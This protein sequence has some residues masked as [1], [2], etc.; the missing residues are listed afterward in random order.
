MASSSTT[1]SGG[2]L[3]GYNPH[4]VRL[5]LLFRRRKIGWTNG[6]ERMLW[7]VLKNG[8][9]T[10]AMV[11]KDD[12]ELGHLLRADLFSIIFG[13]LRDHSIDTVSK[14]DIED[15]G[16]TAMRT[17]VRVV[18]SSPETSRSQISFLCS[19]G[20]SGVLQGK[21]SMRFNKH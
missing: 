8:I 9:V 4:S 17:P 5:A 3:V 14:E 16:T 11:G 20:L 6:N 21:H 1:P 12:G 10:G 2:D 15:S 19:R 13:V 7:R 18:L